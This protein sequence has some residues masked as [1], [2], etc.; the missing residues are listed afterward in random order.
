MVI[1]SHN[2]PSD[3]PLNFELLNDLNQLRSMVPF[4]GFEVK[5]LCLPLISRRFKEM[6]HD[7]SVNSGVAMGWE[8]A[9]R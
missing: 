3:L 7:C 6:V 5:E 1:A 8:F 2:V 4:C 9:A